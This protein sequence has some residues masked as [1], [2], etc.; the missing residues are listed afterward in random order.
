MNY[1]DTKDK[2]WQLIQENK[3]RKSWTTKLSEIF[4][5]KT[6]ESEDCYDENYDGH[7]V[8]IFPIANFLNGQLFEIAVPR[9]Y[10]KKFFTDGKLYEVGVVYQ[11]ARIRSLLK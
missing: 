1:Q 3:A 11:I 2:L 8:H 5:S 10:A 9:F 6:I 7:D 4:E